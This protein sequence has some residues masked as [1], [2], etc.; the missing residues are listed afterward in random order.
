MVQTIPSV[1]ERS[2]TLYRYPFLN[3]SN[4]DAAFRF[5]AFYSTAQTSDSA[6]IIGGIETKN[7]VAQYY[8]DGDF[9]D[10]WRRLSDLYRER[11]GH[12]SIFVGEKTL[13]IGGWSR[14]KDKEE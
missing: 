4:P 8:N 10:K 1:I 14:V 9:S 2:K 6:Y 12:G 11:Y 5:I 7:I 13:I 3:I